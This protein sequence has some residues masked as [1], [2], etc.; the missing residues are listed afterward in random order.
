[1]G[2]ERAATA[3]FEKALSIAEEVYGADHAVAGK[4]RD[5]ITR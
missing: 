1:L 3:A 4:I 5:Q 2:N